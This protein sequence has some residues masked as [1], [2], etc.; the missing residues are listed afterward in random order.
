[1]EPYV[2]RILSGCHSVATMSE[3]HSRVCPSPELA[4]YLCH[5]ILPTAVGDAELGSDL[6]EVGPGPGA[7]TEWLRHRVESVVA[8]EVEP[9][10]ADRLAARF[11]DSNARVVTADASALPIDD[12]S[13]DAA[14]SFTMPH[15]L[16]TAALQNQLLAELLRVLRPGG[17]L[18]GSDSLASDAL[19]QFH[20]GD[21][22]N[23]VDPAGL[24]VRLQTLG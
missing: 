9:E 22:Y 3:N 14:A 13:F 5:D 6:I 1:M 2:L 10:A 18:V 20:E 24:L 17:V 16:A 15:R 8:V 21:T 4:E 23:P 11:P 7:S 19:H 12:E